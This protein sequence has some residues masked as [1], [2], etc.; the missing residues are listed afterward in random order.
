M[1]RCRFG[2]SRD[3]SR[4]FLL[5]FGF[6]GACA[7]NADKSWRE[8]ASHLTFRGHAGSESIGGQPGERPTAI[9][10]ALRKNRRSH[11]LGAVRG[12]DNSDPARRTLEINRV[13]GICQSRGGR[14]GVRV[15]G[16]HSERQAGRLLN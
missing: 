8:V 11:A 16:A 1:G 12:N 4:P 9:R 7:T 6:G 15:Q 3:S 2:S 5:A 14:R 10:P 13:Y